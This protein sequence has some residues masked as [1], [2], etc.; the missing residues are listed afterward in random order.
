MLLVGNAPC[1]ATAT[2]Q[3]LQGKKQLTHDEEQT[4]MAIWAMAS[5]PLMMSNDLTCVSASSKAILL[6]KDVLAVN[7]DLLG[8]MAFRFRVDG[9]SGVQLWRKELVG[10]AV[11]VVIANTHDNA[12]VPSGFEFDLR[13]TGFSPDTHVAVR[14]LYTGEEFH[15]QQSSFKTQAPI[16]PHGVQFLRLSYAPAP[17]VPAGARSFEV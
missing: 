16:P 4:Q 14:N 11:A 15:W 1:G 13:D 10:G 8:R 2:S 9:D 6:N 5:A 17:Y 7:Q 3:A 12:T